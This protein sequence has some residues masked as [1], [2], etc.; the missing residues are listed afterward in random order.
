MKLNPNKCGMGLPR[1]SGAT[2]A[3]GTI[4]L[5]RWT[6]S[7]PVTKHLRLAADL[8]IEKVSSAS[9]LHEGTAQFV[10]CSAV[11]F[12]ALLTSMGSNDCLSFGIPIDDQ[13]TSVVS[14]KKF[15]ARG[16]PAGT[17]T[18]TADAMRW[19]DGPA[20][21][22]IDHDHHERIYTP[23][24]LLQALYEICAPLQHTAHVWAASASSCIYN[25]TTKKVVR[26]IEG[27]RAYIV[28]KDGT[29]IPRA[30]KVL[31]QRSW[32]AGHGYIKISNAGSLLV[33]SVLDDSVFQANRIDYCA[34]AICEPPLVQQK[35][36]PKLHGNPGLVL[37]TSVALPD[38]VAGEL[39]HFNALIAKAK[40]DKSVE[41][42]AVRASYVSGKVEKLVA[43]G[44]DAIAAHALIASAL[45]TDT[46]CGDFVLTTEDG[47]D[48]TVAD[49]LRDK[50][51]WHG[52]KFA[53]PIEPDYRNDRRVALAY[54]NGPGRPCIHS[55][56]HGRRTF[57]LTLAKEK[58]NLI[59]GNRSEYIRDMLQT[60]KTQELFYRRGGELVAI[61]SGLVVP[62][63]EHLMLRSLDQTFRFVRT[64]RV[65]KEFQEIPADLPP[66]IAKQIVN[67]YA[68]EFPS[69]RAVASAPVI[70]LKSGDLIERSGFDLAS[71]MFI[72]V[73]DDW[74][75]VQNEPSI[76][77]VANAVKELW[78]PVRMF[79]YA[80]SIDQTIM[81]T[82]MLTSVVR[83]QL[84][85]APGF[86]FDAPI[87]ASG[88]TLLIKVL[89]ALGGHSAAMSPQPDAKSDDEMR[90]RLFAI[91]R[92]GDRVIVIDNIVGEFDSPSLATMLTSE[93]YSDRILGKSEAA[94]VPSTAL[95]LLSGNN[96]R[97]AGD[98]PR[99]ILRC[100]IDPAIENPHQ[101]SFPFDPVEVVKA[102]RSK[103]LAAAMTILRACI[104]KM[105]GQ[106]S[107]PGRMASFEAWDD[108]VRQTVC[109]L[110]DLQNSNVIPAGS[111]DFP[112]LVDP[113]EAINQAVKDDPTR[114]SLGRLLESWDIEIG[115]GNTASAALTVSRLIGQSEATRSTAKPVPTTGLACNLHDVLIEV[116]GNAMTRTINSKSLGK[117]LA[118]HK[119]RVIDGRRLQRGSNYQ[120][121][122]T[123]WVED[124]SGCGGFGGSIS[125]GSKNTQKIKTSIN[126]GPAGN[127]PTK[128]TKPHALDRDKKTR[129]G[130]KTG[131]GRRQPM[132]GSAA[133]NAASSA[134][135]MA[136]KRASKP[137]CRGPTS[138]RRTS[139]A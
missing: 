84:A 124:L 112:A 16:S 138:T 111:L 100:R 133:A 109:W 4:S 61:E 26:G 123:W 57:T 94:T 134:S 51:A 115:T 119:D 6:A 47:R 139:G 81:L 43:N 59:T 132:I 5:T 99:R 125:N 82:A 75:G 126:N 114:T 128:P 135:V 1:C 22:M 32:L 70:S 106:Q 64:V 121:V 36:K 66:C 63:D 44:V 34:P 28:V 102:K 49:L 118:S 56:A 2:P 88:K 10:Q 69:L 78:G 24:E 9:Q 17:M 117:W 96:L 41:A 137:P 30:A 86:A 31:F 40:A 92:G 72:E 35:Q 120:G 58:I 131:T 113:M 80:E 97:L 91:L 74:P 89:A 93:I 23:A 53:D 108:L 87:Q 38:L 90:K 13:A 12:P 20:I 15:N 101:R 14:R 46:L 136:P 37:D 76:V 110:A 27:Q 18:R 48:V 50:H 95:V 85:T 21:L 116:A 67:A 62:Q 79:P 39:I 71:G 8:T 127:S 73:P 122:A 55:F 19:P 25:R 83:S 42:A 98:L 45:D 129:A 52:S 130:P 54:L 3:T 60:V 107:A 105:D 11:A 29:D 65:K 7:Q 68:S 104:L 33:R 103:L 77:D